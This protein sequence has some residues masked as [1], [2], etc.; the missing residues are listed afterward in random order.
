MQCGQRIPKGAAWSSLCAGAMRNVAKPRH[1]PGVLLSVR[2]WE[3]IW[4]SQKPLLAAETV[5]AAS[6]LPIN[7]QPC[8]LKLM[9]NLCGKCR[10]NNQ[11]K[12]SLMSTRAQFILLNVCS[13]VGPAQL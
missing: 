13:H 10:L 11:S 7:S 5:V 8:S 6:C 4:C 2:W 3:G 1:D 12:D 9:C